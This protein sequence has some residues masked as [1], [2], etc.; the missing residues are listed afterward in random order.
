MFL[1]VGKQLLHPRTQDTQSPTYF[2]SLIMGRARRRILE[3]GRP[4]VPKG[5]GPSA[6]TTGGPGWHWTPLAVF[7]GLQNPGTAFFGSGAGACKVRQCFSEAGARLQACQGAAGGRCGAGVFFV[8]TKYR[9]YDFL[10]SSSFDA[11]Y[12]SQLA[13]RLWRGFF[14]LF[15]FSREEQSVVRWEHV[16]Y[17]SSH[18]HKL[19]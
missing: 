15:G 9:F 3:P 13:H 1:H 16:I 4:S 17:R 8:L 2:P 7:P 14:F 5:Q 11:F 19:M 12:P 10:S 18:A 6:E